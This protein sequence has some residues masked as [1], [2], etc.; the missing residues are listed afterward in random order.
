MQDFL[1]VFAAGN[2]GL[3]GNASS[4][5]AQTVTSPATAKNCI[6]VGATLGSSQALGATT[7]G[8]VTHQATGSIV[9]SQGQN[10]S[11]PF[12]ASATGGAS[13]SKA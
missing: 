2:E 9:S 4:G 5:G 12:Q 13:S 8:Y 3:S 10:V 1:P 6:T 11:Q 7:G